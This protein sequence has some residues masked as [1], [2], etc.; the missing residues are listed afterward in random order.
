MQDSLRNHETQTDHKNTRIL[1]WDIDGTLMTST[2]PGAYKKYF[3]P[4]LE[5]VFGSSGDLDGITV[6]GM[7]DFQIAFEALQ[8]AGFTVDR[9]REKIPA[10][11]EVFP[12]EM[13]R[14]LDGTHS[15]ELLGGVKEL[16]ESTKANPRYINGLLTGN[17]TPAAKIKLEKVGLEDEFDF[18]ISAFGELSHSRNDLPFEAIKKA[19]KKFSYQFDPSQFIII[20]DTPNDILCARNCG[21]KVISV[22]TGRGQTMENLAKFDPDYLFE[23]FSDTEKVLDAL[24]TL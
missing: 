22:A 19:Q 2:Q 16:L 5:K 13:R 11:L 20:G 9:I 21:A 15:H 3:A 12:V 23:D 6:S 24:K 4:A 18:E 1:L 10:M 17:L 14:I 8:N 7:T